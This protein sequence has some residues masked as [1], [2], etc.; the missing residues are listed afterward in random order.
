VADGPTQSRATKGR[1]AAFG[2]IFVSAV[3]SAMSIGI[4]VPILPNLLKQFTGGDTAGAVEWNVVFATC[5][6]MM[7][8]LA[9]PVLGMLADR[10]G[11]RPVLLV[12]LGGL[13][14]DFVF[15]ALAPSLAWLLVGRLISGATSGVFSTANAYVAD[16]TEAPDRARAFGWMGAAFNVGFLAGP[17][18]GGLLGQVNLRLPFVAAAI[19]TLGNAIY[20]FLILP[21]S[22]PPDRR[23]ARFVLR[24]ANPVGSFG[25]LR[26]RDGLP[27][28]AGVYFLTQLAQMVWPSVFVLYTGYRYGWTP[29]VVGLT[30][31]AGGVMG[32]V[33]QTFLVGPV[34]R[35]FG[36]SGAMLA[37]AV[38]AMISL[39][40]YGLAS[41]GVGYWL[42]MPLSCLAG[43]MIPGLQGMMTQ[44]VAADEQGQLQGA[45]QSMTGL[46]AVIGPSLFGLTFAWAIRHP[47]YGLIG[48]PLL[49]ASA[50][51][52][53]S[54]LLG[55]R[56]GRRPWADATV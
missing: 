8:F 7:S 32:V 24:R 9:G 27:R 6:G 17:A 30:M 52:A 54:V 16:I 48:L 26:S 13:G 15:M 2:F 10:W 21:E 11:R 12:S 14:L 55:L 33:V 38:A 50:I 28:L 4:M 1:Q 51:M 40:W 47:A 41:T 22:L 46:A 23:A 49:A 42:G 25:L 19:L 5:G 29:G 20:G 39:G 31:M 3:T 44:R 18:L 34:I 37:G 45:N 36:E 43:L 53:V 35:R 56:A